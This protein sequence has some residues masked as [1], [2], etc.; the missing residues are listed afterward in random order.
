MVSARQRGSHGACTGWV[1]CDMTCCVLCDMT[2]CVLCDMT[3]WVLCD[4][5]CCVLCDMTCWVLCDMTCCVLCDMTCWVLC[6]MT[7]AGGID[8]SPM[9]RSDYKH[10][11]TYTYTH[12]NKDASAYI[13][14]QSASTGP[15]L[16]QVRTHACMSCCLCSGC[17][18]AHCSSS[19]SALTSPHGNSRSWR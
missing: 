17:V 19:S 2:C 3:C 11:H 5:T 6:D 15:H 1:F 13:C 7:C 14:N 4:M 16:Q 18:D 9:V 10:T 12:I 8:L